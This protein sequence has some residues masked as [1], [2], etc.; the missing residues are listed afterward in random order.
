MTRIERKRLQK[1]FDQAFDVIHQTSHFHKGKNINTPNEIMNRME[2]FN[3][4]KTKKEFCPA[5][6]AI[7]VLSEMADILGLE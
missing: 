1:L 3:K 5:C 7:D 2:H 6:M 4:G